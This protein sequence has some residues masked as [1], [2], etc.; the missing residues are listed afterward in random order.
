LVIRIIARVLESDETESWNM[1]THKV[2]IPGRPV[3]IRMTGSNVIVV[4]KF[5]PY[6]QG[7]RA[8]LLV[9]QGEIWHSAANGPPE[10]MP[11]MDSTVVAYGE[12]V[13]FFPLGVDARNAAPVIELEITVSPY[14]ETLAENGGEAAAGDS[15]DGNGQ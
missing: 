9:A 11:M 14:A 6:T 1:D 13:F 15:A 7:K 4:G 8:V 3:S 5:T 12:K 10:Y 2:T